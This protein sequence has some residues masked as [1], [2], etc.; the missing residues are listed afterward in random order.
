LAFPRRKPSIIA[1]ELLNFIDQN[2]G[3]A[4]KW[5]LIKILGNESQFRHW[6][7]EFLIKERFIEEIQESDRTFYRKTENGEFFHKLLKSGKIVQALLRV[8][9]KRLQRTR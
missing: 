6:I 8:S 7:T 5:D 2:S 1:L 3:K 4:S 9:G